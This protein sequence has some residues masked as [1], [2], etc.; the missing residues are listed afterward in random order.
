M[1]FSSYLRAWYLGICHPYLLSVCC[2]GI[3]VKKSFSGTSLVRLGVTVVDLVKVIKA[4]Q[5]SN[6]ERLLALLY[7]LS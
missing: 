1:C 7:S 6:G 3:S 4:E 5:K 2:N